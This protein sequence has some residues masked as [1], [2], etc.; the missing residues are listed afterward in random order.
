MSVAGQ[1]A[2]F[3]F[4]L[5]VV[6]DAQNSTQAISNLSALCARYLAN[7]H[8]IEVVDVLRE[9]RRALQDGVVMTPT[10]I[11]LSPGPNRRIV[12]TLSQNGPVL[13]ALGIRDEAP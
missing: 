12:G 4:R 3:K 2:A 13:A 10:L 11:K 1:A 8:E 6:G 7:R 5:Y 9:P